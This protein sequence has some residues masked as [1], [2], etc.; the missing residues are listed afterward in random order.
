MFKKLFNKVMIVFFPYLKKAMLKIYKS[1]EFIDSSAEIAKINNK[2]DILFD[3]LIYH[4]TKI[5]K[6]SSN[7][8]VFGVLPPEKSGLAIYNSKTFGINN[9]FHIFSQFLLPDSYEKAKE[10]IVNGYKDNFYPINH[11]STLRTIYNYQKKIFILGNSFHNIHYLDAAIRE[12]DK[13]NSYLYCHEILMH[14]LLSAYYE[15][16]EYKKI[17]CNVYPEFNQEITKYTTETVEAIQNIRKLNNGIRAVLLLTGITNVIV[18]NSV[19]RDKLVEELK[20]STFEKIIVIKKL[21]HPI[22]HMPKN[23]IRDNYSHGIDEIKIGTFGVPDDKTKS[24]ITII[25]AVTL[26][27]EKYGIKSKCILVGYD[28]DLYVATNP[29]LQQKY[30]SWYSNNT[31]EQIVSIMEQIDIAVQLRNNPHGESSGMISQLLGL[32]KCI[33]TSENFLDDI[34]EKHCTVIR[35]LISAE[36]LAEILYNVLIN[37]KLLNYSE[38]LCSEFSFKNLS[39]AI[40]KL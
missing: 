39:E 33:I 18:N 32:N 14:N 27:N 7:I 23:T 26:L 8:A 1:A 6:T 35:K 3:K 12:K 30:L 38:Q 40:I 17:L 2:I 22:S 34:F 9:K 19:A 24:T 31:D 29:G 11:Y 37:K 4:N 5:N 16:T 15:F 13:E 25:N 36:E 21:F 10:S 28:V 20:G